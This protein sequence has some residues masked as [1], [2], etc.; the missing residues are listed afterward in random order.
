MSAQ[1][2]RKGLLGGV[3]ASKPFQARINE[4]TRHYRCWIGNPKPTAV[5]GQTGFS[6][7]G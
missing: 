1:R 4:P 6:G 5:V 3:K 7:A 2:K